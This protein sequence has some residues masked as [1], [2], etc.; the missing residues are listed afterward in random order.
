MNDHVLLNSLNELG[1]KIRCEALSSILMISPNEFNKYNNTWA[2]MQD[3]TYHMTLNREFCIKN[4]MIL[5]LEIATFY[6]RQ[7]YVICIFYTKQ[8]TD[9]FEKNY[10]YEKIWVFD[11]S[12]LALVCMMQISGAWHALQFS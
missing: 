9:W 7:K 2:W 1:E 11:F 5:Q 4:V 3:S 8:R 6:E 12:T 10:L